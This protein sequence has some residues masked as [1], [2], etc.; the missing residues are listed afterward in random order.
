MEE[1]CITS[2]VF[3]VMNN[4]TK[5]K[6]SPEPSRVVRLSESWVQIFYSNS[7][8]KTYEFNHVFEPNV[9]GSKIYQYSINEL[10]EGLVLRNANSTVVG[11]GQSN[12]GKSQFLFKYPD[13]MFSECIY[14][15]FQMLD[16]HGLSHTNLK[17]RKLS[18][19]AK[20]VLDN[21]PLSSDYK[22]SLSWYQIINDEVANEA[23]W[24]EWKTIND[25]NHWRR[26]T[27]EK[28]IKNKIIGHLIVS[29][30]LHDVKRLR[31][32]ELTF[33]DILGFDH[34]FTEKIMSGQTET[35]LDKLTVNDP[36]KFIRYLLNALRRN[37]LFI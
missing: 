20:S 27:L 24:Q 2:K 19:V 32:S 31:D 35:I 30:K 1:E 6:E 33:V 16:E 13:C 14:N 17:N 12:L 11:Y 18:K 22:L 7:L 15:I 8:D 29:I 25:C 4:K 36:S 9:S 26:E 21:K 3:V 10:V 23:I 37:Q 34:T 5:A 28:H